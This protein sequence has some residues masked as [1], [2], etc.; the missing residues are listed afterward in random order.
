MLSP[1]PSEEDR[2]QK[3]LFAVFHNDRILAQHSIGSSHTHIPS[4]ISLRVLM[5]GNLMRHKSGVFR[6][7]TLQWDG[8]LGTLFPGY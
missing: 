5:T 8:C 4:V 2:P 3:A 1:R 7:L 6:G